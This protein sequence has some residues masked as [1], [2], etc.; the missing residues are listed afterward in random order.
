M[1]AKVKYPRAFWNLPR[2]RLIHGSLVQKVTTNH[3]K[4]PLPENKHHIWICI[5]IAKTEPGVNEVIQGIMG[6]AWNSY[7][8]VA[9][10][11]A[12]KA[13][14]SMMLAAPAFA[15]K[16]DDGDTDPKWSRREG[17]AGCWLFQLT[18]YLPEGIPCYDAANNV[19][20]DPKAFQLGDFVDGHISA[21]INGEVG[22][23]AGIFLN[24]LF[25]RWIG[26]GPRITLGIDP[27][28]VM[29]P[30]GGPGYQPSAGAP[31]PGAAA[32]PPTFQQPQMI[33][34]AQQ[35][36]ARLGVQYHAGWRVDEAT[37][38][39]IADVPAAQAPSAPGFTS[40]PANA[41][42]TGFS[43]PGNAGPAPGAPANGPA[44]QAGAPQ[45]QAAPSGAQPGYPGQTAFP[46]N[47]QP[48]AGFHTGAPVFGGR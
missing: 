14:I 25:I 39:Y 12:V 40:T 1:N 18:T 13:Q 16:I 48:V 41:P 24:P 5:A 23:T 43:Q 32:T 17:A 31:M 26:S 29:A 4:Q 45:F 46:S 27:S 11:E 6:H 20:I 9:G 30:I 34:T 19:K 37:R 7:Q 28:S 47:A 35:Q 15:W 21:E 22:N 2:G 3:Q 10:A 8:A 44:V 38:T 33:E 36:A 42:A